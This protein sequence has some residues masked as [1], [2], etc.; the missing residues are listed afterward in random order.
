MLY[1]HTSANESL[2]FVVLVCMFKPANAPS[3]RS[4]LMFS[5]GESMRKHVC[6]STVHAVQPAVEMQRSQHSPTDSIVSSSN[7]TL[8]TACKPTFPA[9]LP[10]GRP[11]SNCP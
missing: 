9:H 3:S 8:P 10:A 7:I 4:H 5:F 6:H 11:K 1:H 2:T